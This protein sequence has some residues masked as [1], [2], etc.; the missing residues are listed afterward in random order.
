MAHKIGQVGRALQGGFA[1]HQYVSYLP[2][3]PVLG[4]Y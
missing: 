2:M 1:C 3:P 4:L